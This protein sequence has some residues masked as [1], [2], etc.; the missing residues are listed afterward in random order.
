VEAAI[1]ALVGTLLGVLGTLA[2][3]VTRVRAEDTRSQREALR[4]V[5]ADFTA[6][7]ARM[8]NITFGLTAV[9]N[10]QQLSLMQEAHRDARINYE[11]LR[12]ILN[13]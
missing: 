13:F 8:I 4:L 12:L 6:S 9:A 10:S 7:A 1:F 3:E 5:V 2:V 11:R